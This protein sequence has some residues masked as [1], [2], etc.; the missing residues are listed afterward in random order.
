ML[1]QP[2]NDKTAH[3][4]FP[5]KT[6]LKHFRA[7][8]RARANDYSHVSLKLDHLAHAEPLLLHCEMPIT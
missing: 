3:T 8:P 7:I 5:H 1:E 2:S 6:S 4:E